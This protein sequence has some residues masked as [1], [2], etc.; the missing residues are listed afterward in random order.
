[1]RFSWDKPTRTFASGAAVAV[2]S[3]LLL[4]GAMQPNL[5]DDGR[6]AG[7][8]MIAGWAGARSTGPFDP[9]AT[10]ASYAGQIPDYVLGTDW[11]KTLAWPAEPAATPEPAA[12]E[13]APRQPPPEPVGLTRAD[14]DD[15]PPE[16]KAHY[17]SL[18]GD[19]APRAQV[20]QAVDAADEATGPVAG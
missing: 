12:R 20:G 19:I 15:A 8:Q 2:V 18:G 13:A 11:K 3:G 5:G 9:G 4:G 14:Y 10:Y 6:P 1:M 7:P 17:P 16:P